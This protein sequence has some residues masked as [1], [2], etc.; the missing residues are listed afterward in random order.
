MRKVGDVLL[1][2]LAVLVTIPVLQGTTAAQVIAAPPAPPAR[3]T[4]G[5]PLGLT[6]ALG[7]RSDLVR[8]PGLDAFSATDGLPQSAL[9][10]W[11]RAGGDERAGL[12]VGFEWNH[13]TTIDRA[14]AS[15]TE[16]VLDRLTLTFEGRV[17]IGTRW[18]AFGKIAPGLLRDRARI[19]EGSAPGDRY[20]GLA[21][22]A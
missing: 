11:Y 21:S 6:A 10:V 9:A 13:G 16:L 20:G 4:T 5:K 3:W 17:P 8:S 14:R 1:V 15:E 22:G 7:F 12:A 18:A 2:S 19:S